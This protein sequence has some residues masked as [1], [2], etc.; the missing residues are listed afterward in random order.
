MSGGL[1]Q[2]AA[3]GAENKYL[4]GNPQITFFK[5][6]YKRH[7][8]FSRE[9]VEVGFEG[10]GCLPEISQGVTVL[11]MKVPR[12]G[13]LLEKTYLKVELPPII[14]SIYKK[15][16]WVKN[17]G[18]VMIKSASL[19]IGG[20]K[21]E[22]V[23]SEW[24]HIYQ[25]VNL[26]GE[27][28]KIY[29]YL[30]GNTA[31]LN[32][33]DNLKD[34]LMELFSEFCQRHVD[35]DEHYDVFP[36]AMICKKDL[37]RDEMSEFLKTTKKLYN[38]QNPYYDPRCLSDVSVLTPSILG[39]TLYVPIPFCFTKDI[40][41]SLPLVALQYHDVE[42]QLE[43]S[44][45]MDLFT[46]LEWQEDSKSST[47]RKPNPL[48]PS[49]KL[50]YFVYTDRIVTNCKN[51]TNPS[52]KIIDDCLTLGR[53][54]L[55]YE[56]NIQNMYNDSTFNLNC[57]LELFFIFLDE[58]ERKKFAEMSHEYLIQQTV[59]REATGFHGNSS[60]FEMNL[61]NPVK[62]LFW[63]LQRDD[64][65]KYN[66]WFNFTNLVDSEKPFWYQ[67]KNEYEKPE[68]KIKVK[69]QNYKQLT[70]D[71]LVKAKL[72]FNGIDRFEF[73]D[74]VYFNYL[75]PFNGHSNYGQG[76]NIYSFALEPEKSQPS[77]AVNMSMISNVSLDFE[78]LVP[79]IDP[80]VDDLL[81]QQDIDPEKKKYL[82]NCL[83]IDVELKEGSCVRDKQIYK[84]TYN[85]RVY[86]V[87][88]N[89]LK[90]V[91]GMGG[92]AYTN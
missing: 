9:S 74:P 57:S 83:G 72:T 46:I 91:A 17:L 55:D 7:T 80:E 71:I 62:E 11:K 16:K 37:D 65:P 43:F 1:I 13:D 32:Q 29:D 44:P 8:N 51:P 60:S 12:I 28:R 20:A 70:P 40:G 50:S 85:L 90:I 86:C 19:F 30:V 14:S 78:T 54:E 76:I 49:H 77:G 10:S 58:T 66:L 26:Q 47:R 64:F 22:T 45:V 79:P 73:K 39:R 25:K 63:V 68:K 35:F 38:P 5:M 88:Y 67:S 42:I 33:V 92:L 82:L 27:K 53:D 36:S 3:Y 18:E 24:I 2:L 6:V 34:N 41:L 89:I 56:C 4:M 87:N 52:L 31:D 48:K 81:N 61:Y 15:F 59:V 69:R 75:S 23:T 84:Y 21:I